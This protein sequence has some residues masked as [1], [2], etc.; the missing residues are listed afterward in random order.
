MNRDSTSIEQ[1]IADARAGRIGV[2]EMLPLLLDGDLVVP[3]GGEVRDDGQGFQPVLFDR[4]GVPMIAAFTTLDRVG[5][6]AKLA[7]FAL[8]IK[9][10]A[11]L[12]LVPADHGVVINPGWPEGFEIDPAGL[13][14]LIADAA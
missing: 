12:A 5:E 4:E 11:F 6:T 14:R 3:S 10:R 7:P 2:A 8:S 1:A 9:G 13:R